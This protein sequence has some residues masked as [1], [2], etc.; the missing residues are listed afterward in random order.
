MIEDGMYETAGVPGRATGFNLG[1]GY[2]VT[3]GYKDGTGRFRSVDWSAGGQTGNAVYGYLNNSDLIEQLTINNS[4]I[5]TY[6]YESNR[7]L[8][9]QVKNEFN[10]QLISQYDYNYNNLGLRE[11]SDTSGSA[12]TETP[13]ELTP[14][15]STYTTNSLNQ[16]TQITKDN[17]QQ[18]TDTLNYDDDGNL[19]LIISVGATKVYKY[20][21]ENR[22][23]AVEPSTPING[24]KKVEFVYDYMGRRIQKKVY[25]YV[26]DLW[27]LSSDT[28][29]F[30]DGWNLILE[31]DGTGSVHKSYVYGLDLSQSVDGAGGVGGLI[32][33]VDT[34][35]VYH[36][37]Y[38]V[39]GNIRQLIKA[40]DGSISAHYE[41]DPFGILLKATGLLVNEN[42]L[43][44]STKYYDTEIGLYYYGYRY[45]S[46]SLGRWINRD[47]LGEFGDYNLYGFVNNDPIK[48]YDILGL[49]TVKGVLKILCCSEDRH[50]VDEIAKG[51]R[52]VLWFDKMFITWKFPDGS[53][54]REKSNAR[55]RCK[56]H[57]IPIEIHTRKSLSNKEAASNIAHETY[58]IYLHDLKLT[59]VEE[60]VKVRIETEKFRKRHSMT[61]ILPEY[62]N[63]DNSIN[64]EAIRSSVKGS[65][66]YTGNV[67][68][69]TKQIID[70]DY[71]G[72]LHLT[73]PTE[74]YCPQ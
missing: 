6:S 68:E 39:N 5:T 62:R 43:R 32:S 40:S 26:S 25:T 44:F 38:D 57:V 45:Y 65:P 13:I 17:G 33:V 22:L 58:H 42:P 46:A 14:E 10:S 31:M 8:K 15:T 9:T 53:T 50:I 66:A 47:P 72:T 35:E 70:I 21:A 63:R 27:S 19:T 20:N 24:D 67:E 16:Y 49:W 37:L 7:N 34:G 69:G 54:K 71:D 36:F 18:T 1:D 55:G 23:I 4:L 41:Y 11:H 28:L 48:S 61:P 30:Y 64:E 3:Y 2:N 59:T 51:K 73:S 12:F 56:K 74:W 29:F 52:V 60:E